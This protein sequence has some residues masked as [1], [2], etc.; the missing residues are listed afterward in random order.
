[1]GQLFPPVWHL[2]LFAVRPASFFFERPA[3]GGFRNRIAF[4]ESACQRVPG[5]R[6]GSLEEDL[7]ETMGQGL[8]ASVRN[9]FRISG[10]RQASLAELFEEIHALS[11]SVGIRIH[12]SGPFPD[13]DVADHA[14]LLTWLREEL[15]NLLLEGCRDDMVLTI[16][17]GI[18][19]LH[20]VCFPEN[21]EI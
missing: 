13:T 20:P 5:F 6:S 16:S 9:R 17:G 1:M 10:H 3:C 12:A 14:K 8:F 4:S 19:A 21:C 18:P 15:A 7:I 2:N 11:T